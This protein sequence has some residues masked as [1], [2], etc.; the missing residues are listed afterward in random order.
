MHAILLSRGAVIDIMTPTCCFPSRIRLLSFNS[1]PTSYG[2]SVVTLSRVN[3]AFEARGGSTDCVGHV[4]SRARVRPAHENLFHG[5]GHMCC[6]RDR[7]WSTE[8]PGAQLFSDVANWTMIN[9]T[10]RHA[11]RG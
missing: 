1:C 6:D 10:R 9:V 5:V 4:F 3:S 11:D 8:I 2:F 7:D